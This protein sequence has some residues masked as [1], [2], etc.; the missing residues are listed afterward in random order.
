MVLSGHVGVTAHRTDTGTHGNKI[1]SFMTTIH[2][3]KSNP[4]RLF[5]VDTEAGT[6]KT[7]VYAP[8]TNETWDD[9]AETLTGID[10]V[11]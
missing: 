7:W 4:V 10:W 2:S 11:E 3:G 9:A 5:T 1:Y 8:W 6:L